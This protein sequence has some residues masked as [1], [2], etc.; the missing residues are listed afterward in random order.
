MRKKSHQW[1]LSSFFL[2]FLFIL[3]KCAMK[4]KPD[5]HLSETIALWKCWLATRTWMR[6]FKYAHTHT[7]TQT[8]KLTHSYM[9]FNSRQR[10]E[11]RV[12]LSLTLLTHTHTH[13]NIGIG[14]FKDSVKRNMWWLSIFHSNLEY[15]FQCQRVIIE[16]TLIIITRSIS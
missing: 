15:F 3:K 7:R 14:W 1:I 10:R 11:Q 13:F 5:R 9:H 16:K 8:H 12:K 2:V 6:F 4:S